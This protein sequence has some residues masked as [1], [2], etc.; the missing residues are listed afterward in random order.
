MPADCP[1]SRKLVSLYGSAW[2]SCGSNVENVS[3][4]VERSEVLQLLRAEYLRFF[5]TLF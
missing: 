4:I 1:A 2:G 3:R 5:L